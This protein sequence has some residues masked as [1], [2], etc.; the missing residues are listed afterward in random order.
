MNAALKPLFFKLIQYS[1]ELLIQIQILNLQMYLNSQLKDVSAKKTAELIAVVFSF[2][3]LL[4]SQNIKLTSENIE[5][6][7]NKY[8]NVL[9]M[10][11][12]LVT[13]L[14]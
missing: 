12:N 10:A 3:E 13:P 14:S 6:E 8:T 9:D 2:R 11:E 4:V 1:P 7:L 5:R